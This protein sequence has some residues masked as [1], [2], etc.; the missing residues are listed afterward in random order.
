MLVIYQYQY[1]SIS[2]YFFRIKR[3]NAPQKMRNA[4]KV[5]HKEYGK[6]ALTTSSK[7]K[8]KRSI[9]HVNYEKLF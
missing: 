2:L 9:K 5:K 1:F 4:A 8:N 6:A 3:N 7:T